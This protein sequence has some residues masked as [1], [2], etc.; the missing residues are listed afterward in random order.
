MSVFLRLSHSSAALV[1]GRPLTRPEDTLARIWLA[2]ASLPSL[3]PAPQPAIKT[4]ASAAQSLAVS[5]PVILA[6]VSSAP[7]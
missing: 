1:C 4:S 3:F 2:A 5:L 6:R 7:S